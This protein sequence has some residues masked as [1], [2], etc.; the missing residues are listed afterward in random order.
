MVRY[1]FVPG[2]PRRYHAMKIKQFSIKALLAATV[3][4]A[5]ATLAY[6][7]LRPEPENHVKPAGWALKGT[8]NLPEGLIYWFTDSDGNV[9]TGLLVFGNHP[10]VMISHQHGDFHIPELK[11]ERTS[12]PRDGAMY[13]L[14]P[15]NSLVQSRLDLHKTVSNW[16]NYAEWGSRITDEIE[17]NTW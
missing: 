10:T 17:A 6:L 9:V 16:K 11:T 3:F 14:S 13:I 1:S 8:G 12:L 5:I 7:A 15:R 2:E 4:C